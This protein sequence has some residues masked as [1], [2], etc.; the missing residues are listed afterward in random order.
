MV[1]YTDSL[2]ANDITDYLEK[3]CGI[4]AITQKFENFNK[5]V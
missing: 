5:D 1:G 2:V 3:A 4:T